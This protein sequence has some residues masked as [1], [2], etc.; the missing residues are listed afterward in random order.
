MAF[1]GW[2]YAT[3]SSLEQPLGQAKKISSVQN[4]YVLHKEQ[5]VCASH[6]QLSPLSSRHTRLFATSHTLSD[7]LHIYTFSGNTTS[8]SN[9]FYHDQKDSIYLDSEH[10]SISYHSL[11]YSLYAK[12]SR[13][14]NFILWSHQAHAFFNV[15]ALAVP[16]AWTPLIFLLKVLFYIYLFI[17]SLPHW[18]IKFM[19]FVLVVY[20]S[21]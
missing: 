9:I 17:V 16:S 2:L 21:A 3:A 7:L 12:Y 5:E 4:I 1:S 13:F 14:L 20:C 18:N 11:S 15:F 19:T 10:I 8:C 6:F